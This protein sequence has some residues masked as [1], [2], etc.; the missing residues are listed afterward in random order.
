MLTCFGEDLLMDVK[1]ACRTFAVKWS[2]FNFFDCEN[3]SEII[4]FHSSCAASVSLYLWFSVKV[5]SVCFASDG[6]IED[7]CSNTADYS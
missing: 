6:P 1:P 3:L 2:I 7:I 4:P 5:T